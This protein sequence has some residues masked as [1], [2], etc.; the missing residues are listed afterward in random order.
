MKD[1][2]AEVAVTTCT[3]AAN[4]VV[5]GK[6]DGLEFSVRYYACTSSEAVAAFR[7]RYRGVEDVSVEKSLR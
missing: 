7:L 4:W 6:L 1:R 2:D 5:T 3:R